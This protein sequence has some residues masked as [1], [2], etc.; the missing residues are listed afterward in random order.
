MISTASWPLS[1]S[2]L[3]CI[4]AAA[5]IGF[6]SILILVAYLLGIVILGAL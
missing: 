3:I 5:I 4:L 2:L 1:I 6:E